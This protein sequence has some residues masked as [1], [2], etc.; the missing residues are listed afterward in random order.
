MRSGARFIALLAGFFLA[1]GAQIWAQTGSTSLRGTVT[2][3][4]G[5][6]ISQAKVTLSSSD[7]GFQRTV[8]SGETGSYEFVQ[9][10]PG[11]YQLTVEMPGFRKYEQKGL[12]LLVDTPA[13]INMKLSVGTPATEPL[14]ISYI[15]VGDSFEV[16]GLDRE[17]RPLEDNGRDVIFLVANC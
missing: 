3:V 6:T 17:G 9:L 2:D 11:A 4:S 7:R 16:R 13:T 1:V 10:Q 12:Q 14:S 8:L 5:A 15:R